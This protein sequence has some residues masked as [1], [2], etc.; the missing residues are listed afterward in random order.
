MIFDKCLVI[1]EVCIIANFLIFYKNLVNF[2][3]CR[4]LLNLSVQLPTL[5][6][7]IFNSKNKLVWL[8][9]S[10]MLSLFSFQALEE[11]DLEV[12]D[13]W[14]FTELSILEWFLLGFQTCKN[15]RTYVFSNSYRSLIEFTAVFFRM[16]FFK[17]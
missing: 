13:F 5:F 9:I 4:N 11:S 14:L 3:K 2:F 6:I 12:L 8:I 17:L 1:G 16:R 7:I 10:S 15:S